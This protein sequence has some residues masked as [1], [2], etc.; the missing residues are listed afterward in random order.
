MT[1]AG[2]SRRI[3]TRDFFTIELQTEA[4][5]HWEGTLRPFVPEL[6]DCADVLAELKSLLPVFFPDLT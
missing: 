5:R 2:W 4:H 6:P 1:T 3:S